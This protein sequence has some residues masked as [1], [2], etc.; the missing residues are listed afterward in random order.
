[1]RVF[2]LIFCLT[3]SAKAQFGSYADLP[4]LASSSSAAAAV[5]Y[6]VKQDFEGA[7]YD[8]GETW[9]ESGTGTI[10]EDYTTV[11]LEGSESL[12]INMASQTAKTLIVFPA[13]REVWAYFLVRFLRFS[14]APDL[15]GGLNE[16]SPTQATLMRQSSGLVSLNNSTSAQPTNS[17]FTN[18]TYSVWWHEKRTLSNTGIVDIAWST[19]TTKPLTNWAG[20]FARFSNGTRTHDLT[21]ITLFTTQ[22]SL[23]QEAIFDHVRVSTNEIGDNPP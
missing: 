23:Q 16:N 8:N 11:V 9:V 1:M 14:N 21:N 6:L 7:G 22:F 15:L 2:I 5:T 13:Q 20:Q 17:V 3:L 10:N 4:F 12:R 19:N 18:I